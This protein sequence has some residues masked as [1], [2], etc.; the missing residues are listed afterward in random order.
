MK[1]WEIIKI[2]INHQIKSFAYLFYERK[3][4]LIIFKKFSRTN[5]YELYVLW[6][7]II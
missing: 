7:W 5:W 4:N 2:K 6:M 1:K 3:I